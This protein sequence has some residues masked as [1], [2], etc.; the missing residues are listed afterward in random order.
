MSLV[1]QKGDIDT[2]GLIPMGTAKKEVRDH[3]DEQ[4]GAVYD[5]R[6]GMEQ[7]PKY[8]LALQLA[9]ISGDL[10][11]LDVGCGTGAFLK[12]VGG[13]AIGIDLASSLLATARQKA[14]N[15]NFIQ[16]DAEALPFR[17]AI[18]SDIYCFTVIQN[19]LNP[20]I[21]LGEMAR[22]T[23]RRGQVVVTA[24]R[25]AFTSEVFENLFDSYPWTGLIFSDD[26]PYD[27]VACASV[28]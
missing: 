4:G 22:V 17:K 24:T 23:R 21:A 9:P 15:A 19:I 14:N 10:P 27:L 7:L 5:A 3:Y 6:Y 16:G 8:D 18:F 28:G 13:T 11:Y 26:D 2:G 20:M 12:Q 1:D 25:K